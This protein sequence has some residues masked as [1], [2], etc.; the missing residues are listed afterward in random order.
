MLDARRSARD[1]LLRAPAGGQQWIAGGSQDD[2]L[3]G[4]PGNDHLFG[5]RGRD[6][7]RG[8][9]GRDVGTGGPD[10]DECRSIEDESGCESR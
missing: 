3:I 8:M 1:D 10:V 2:V 9:A 5:Q 7:L 4:G 6:L